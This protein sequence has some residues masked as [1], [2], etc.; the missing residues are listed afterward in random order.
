VRPAKE[1]RRAAAP[2]ESKRFRTP[3]D[4][5]DRAKRAPLRAERTGHRS[6]RP[7]RRTEQEELWRA[8]FLARRI[9]E[10]SSTRERSVLGPSIS[11]RIVRVFRSLK[12]ETQYSPSRLEMRQHLPRHPATQHEQ[13][14]SETTCYLKSCR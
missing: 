8:G 10:R 7:C 3:W 12:S 13:N 2:P 11:L 6:C 14:L 9:E 5:A 4:A 1:L